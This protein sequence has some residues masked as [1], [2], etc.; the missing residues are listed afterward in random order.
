MFLALFDRV[1]GRHVKWLKYIEYR[2]QRDSYEIHNVKRR[3]CDDPL[4]ILGFDDVE[5]SHE[6]P[7]RVSASRDVDETS[8]KF[9]SL[10][11]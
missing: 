10:Q 9:S 8:P 5:V 7:W 4:F 3:E 6:N 1:R 11:H 2:I